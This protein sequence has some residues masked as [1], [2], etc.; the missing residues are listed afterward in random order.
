MIHHNSVWA[1]PWFCFMFA[2]CIHCSSSFLCSKY[3]PSNSGVLLQIPVGT[4]YLNTRHS[5]SSWSLRKE[6]SM[7]KARYVNNQEKIELFLFPKCWVSECI[8]IVLLACVNVLPALWD[9]SCWERCFLRSLW[10]SSV[11]SWS[12]PKDH[13]GLSFPVSCSSPGLCHNV[14]NPFQINADNSFVVVV[15]RGDRGTQILSG[16]HLQWDSNVVLFMYLFPH[17]SVTYS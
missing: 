10:E 14:S 15:P 1:F 5:S 13:S 12:D 2:T 3:K 9:L 11:F 6:Q 16:T 17:L 4:A 8:L 7:G